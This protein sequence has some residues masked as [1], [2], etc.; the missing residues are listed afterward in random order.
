MSNNRKSNSTSSDG[1]EAM[2]G[3][4]LVVADKGFI[5]VGDIEWQE[6]PVLG[7]F[8]LITNCSNVRKWEHGGFGGITAGAKTAE[9]TLDEC[10]PQYIPRHAVVSLSPLAEGWLND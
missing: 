9:A 1:R 5:F 3:K 4:H 10:R 6:H 7:A 2:T 8:L